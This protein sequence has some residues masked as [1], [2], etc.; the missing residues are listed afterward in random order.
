MSGWRAIARRINLRHA[1]R[2]RLRTLLTIAGVASGVA[3]TFSINVINSTL[4][5][6]F[7]S[8]VRELAGDAELEVAAA[9]ASGLPAATVDEVAGV[10]GVE[11]AVPILRSTS[12]ISGFGGSRRVLVIGATPEFSTLV[13]RGLGPLAEMRVNVRGDPNG[14]LLAE[15]LAEDLRVGSGDRVA[16]QTP[17]GTKA[18]EIAGTVGGPLVDALN[19]GDVGVM[20]LP[21]AQDLFAKQNRVD[22]IYVV[23]DTD[24]SVAD[25]ERSL[26]DALGGMAT[27]GPPGE[28]GAGFERVF[29]SLGTLLSM[30]GTVALFV[31]LFVVYNT[32]SMSLA[33]RRRE[34]SM[35]LAFGAP[36]RA[37]FG[38]F[39]AE[40]LVLGTVASVLGVAGGLVLAQVL[41]ERATEALSFLPLAAAGS[42][43][44]APQAVAIGIAGGIV[45][46][47][48]GAYIPARRVLRVSPIESLRPDAAYEWTT[49]TTGVR[50]RSFAGGL[51]GIAL[52][53]VC[54]IAFLLAPDERWI[55][56][57][58]LVF[59]LGGVTLLLPTVVPWSLRLLR[60]VARRGFGTV[61]R[62]SVDALE[63]NPGRST[64]T[65][66][67]L[68]LTLGLVVGVASALGSYRAQVD[69]L[70]NALVGADLYVSSSSYTGVT[71][72]QPLAA[73]VKAA[74]KDVPGVDFV[75]PLRFTFIE[76]GR[77]Q[78]LVNAIPVG[79]AL[80][81]GASTDLTAITEDP[82]GFTAGLKRGDIAIS[83]LT[84]QT[85]GLDVGDTLALPTP[86][87]R[88]T[89][90]IAATYDDLISLESIYMGYSTY[91][92]YWNDHTADEFGVLVDPGVSHGAVEARLEAVVE[93]TDLPAEV[94]TREE[95]GGRIIRTVESTFSLA[96]GV[97]LAALIVAIFTIANTMFTAILERRWE[98]GLQRA[99]GMSGKQLGR[100]V[101]LEAA[102]IG[103]VGGVGGAVLGTASGVVM[104]TAMQA[105]F[106]WNVPF[107]TPWVLI[108][109]SVG[110]GV[111]VAAGAGA[112]PSRLAVRARIIESLRYE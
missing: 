69:R 37:V 9:N 7:R 33:E 34:I 111:L 82:D 71:S 39:L 74:I 41:V 57:V 104:T 91:T 90:R 10:E 54:F 1:R 108:A 92:K 12:R 65:V 52:S 107:E 27:I 76:L 97:Q 28:R 110:L 22:S 93:A 60:P 4:V 64:F 8:S 2:R 58:G 35:V 63:K 49:T 73:D 62:L 72:D 56:S 109:A 81:R 21:A 77:R 78:A 83:S 5:T 11:R 16:V 105:Q 102:S 98:M 46:S 85:R 101:L 18:V 94:Y 42:V 43:E 100:T 53:L 88:T 80:E 6:S 61:G 112:I 17:E 89:F 26:E 70:I 23:V 59:G 45:V 15:G 48:I 40:A 66:A 51:A 84:S 99:L 103:V 87:G 55:V 67:A 79:P 38:A 20:L 29:A 3:L 31:A 25:A 106:A 13:P 86:T 24:V 44:V 50:G 95:L 14:L 75:Y 30:G 36:P 96:N 47:L 32:M 19:G 68:V